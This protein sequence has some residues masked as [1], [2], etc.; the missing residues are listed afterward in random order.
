MTGHDLRTWAENDVEKFF[1]ELTGAPL[2]P[3]QVR[4]AKIRDV[5]FLHTFPLYEK[6]DESEAGGKEFVSTRRILTNEGYISSDQ[7]FKHDLLVESSNGS[8]Q[9][10]KKHSPPRSVGTSKVHVVTVQNSKEGPKKARRA[11]KIIV[12]DVSRA[13]LN[14]ESRRELYIRPPTEDSKPRHVGKLLRTL[15]GTQNAANAWD[16]FFNSAAIDQGYDIGLSSPC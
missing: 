15:C 2:D 1:D 11:R 7:T 6:I 14:P 10:W 5:E 13:H 4:L 16:E 9:R 8:H 3:E 12:L